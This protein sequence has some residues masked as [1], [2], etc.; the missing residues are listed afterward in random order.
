M[1]KSELLAKVATNVAGQFNQLDIAGVMPEILNALIEAAVPV[2]VEDI[3]DIDGAVLDKLQAGDKVVKITGKQKHAYWV[4][5]K[6]EGV[7]Q[8]ICLTYADA[9]GTETVS[10]DFTDDGWVYNSTDRGSFA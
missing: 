10:Y 1:T 9:A 5:Y 8:G 7:G 3:T 2:E 4:S 6:G